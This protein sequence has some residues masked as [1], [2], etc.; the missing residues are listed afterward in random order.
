MVGRVIYCLYTALDVLLGFAYIVCSKLNNDKKKKRK[1]KKN[2]SD[3]TGERK[4]L[5]F[6]YRFGRCENQK[7]L[8]VPRN[9]YKSKL[10]PVANHQQEHRISIFV[11]L[12]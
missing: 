3:L 9:T 11:E 1:K 4:L 10:E 7:L 6:N 12:Y 5:R 2:S 8:F